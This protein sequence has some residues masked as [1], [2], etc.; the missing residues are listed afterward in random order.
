MSTDLD[1][2]LLGYTDSI[3]LIYFYHKNHG[4]FL[5]KSSNHDENVHHFHSSHFPNFFW[6]KFICECEKFIFKETLTHILLWFFNKQFVHN[7]QVYCCN[8]GYNPSANQKFA[9]P[10]RN[11]R[12]FFNC[13]MQAR[14]RDFLKVVSF[15]QVHFIH[16]VKLSLVSPNYIHQDH[17]WI[18]IIPDLVWCRFPHMRPHVLWVFRIQPVWQ[19][20]VTIFVRLMFLWG[21]GNRSAICLFDP[22]HWDSKLKVFFYCTSIRY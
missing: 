11:F 12:T 3:R 1:Q 6:K 16:S 7:H 18:R 8:I 2:F 10:L 13:L 19:R 15:L 5:H 22:K 14:N 20:R 9:P 4:I 17:S 21:K